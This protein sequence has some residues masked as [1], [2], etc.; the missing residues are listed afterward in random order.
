MSTWF[1]FQQGRIV[2]DKMVLVHCSIK[3]Y[4]I[5]S[6]SILYRR[7]EERWVAFKEEE[8]TNS[9]PVEW[10]CWLNKRCKRAPTS[11]VKYELLFFISP[12]SNFSCCYFWHSCCFYMS[13]INDKDL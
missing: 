5:Q 1:N 11:E 7:E 10:I 12:L 13:Q 3:G 2:A 8:D 4:K 9:I 6:V